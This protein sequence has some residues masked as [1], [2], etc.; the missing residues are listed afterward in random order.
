MPP[1]LHGRSIGYAC[2]TF[3]PVEHR[4][5]SARC[6]PFIAIAMRV[7]FATLR[8][9]VPEQLGGSQQSIHTLL[10]ALVERGH[11]CEAVATLQPGPRRLLYRGM[12]RLS[13]RRDFG[14][15]DSRP[16]YPTYRAWYEFVPSLLGARLESN[17]PDLVVADF[18]SENPLL[19]QA[20]ARQIPTLLR[21]SRM[22]PPE[23]RVAIPHDPFLQA[24]SNSADMASRVRAQYGIETPVIY[25]PIDVERFRTAR[26]NP[27][28][29]TFFNPIAIKGVETVLDVAAR[30]PHRHFQVVEVLRL[31][32]AALEDLRGRLA[33]LPNVT[34]CRASPDVRPVYSKTQLLLVPSQWEEP[35][36]RVVVEAQAS[37]IPCIVRD[38]GGLREAVGEGGILMAPS[39]GSTEW[40]EVVESVLRN[41]DRLAALSAAATRNAARPEFSLR[42]H[43]AQFVAVAESHVAAAQRA[44]NTS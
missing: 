29:V 12:R 28:C 19:P 21:I 11:D 33:K 22:W 17:R 30:L 25:P 3:P 6:R 34:F 7:V 15:K 2:R 9:H 32:S 44:S 31:S 14:L 36:G 27:E 10:Q 23:R 43:V 24:Y 16:G 20:L 35:F 38:S 18:S 39:A 13:G 37:G 1:I 5:T 26:P 4:T 8:G 41:P 40:A 42:H